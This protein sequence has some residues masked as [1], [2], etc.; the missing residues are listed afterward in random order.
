MGALHE[1]LC[2]FMITSRRIILRIRNI[3]GKIHTE[4]KITHIMANIFFTKFMPVMRNVEIHG[5]AR[6]TRDD[7]IILRMCFAVLLYSDT[8]ANE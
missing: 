3:S 8:S 7:K 4:N 6:Q 5:T 2:T 1:E